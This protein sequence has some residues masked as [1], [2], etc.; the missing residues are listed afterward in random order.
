MTKKIKGNGRPINPEEGQLWFEP[1]S[2]TMREWDG[3]KW[4]ECTTAQIGAKI[5]KRRE[6]YA[7][8]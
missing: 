5:R 6:S 7:R 1:V 2:A 4:A 3:E 8:R